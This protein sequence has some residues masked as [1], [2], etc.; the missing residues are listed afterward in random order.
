M[1]WWGSWSSHHTLNGVNSHQ[2]CQV[3]TAVSGISL[4]PGNQA[5]QRSN[6]APENSNFCCSATPADL[7]PTPSSTFFI[8]CLGVTNIA[9][10]LDFF[11]Q[12]PIETTRTPPDE[13]GGRLTLQ[14]QTQMQLQGVCWGPLKLFNISVNTGQV[15]EATM[16]LIA[17]DCTWVQ[18]CTK[19]CYRHV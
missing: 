17:I 2:T 11:F 4:V 15:R 5:G 3:V 13:H 1:K 10:T 7:I 9:K 8:V 19:T 12:I 14:M 18:P 6:K 16:S